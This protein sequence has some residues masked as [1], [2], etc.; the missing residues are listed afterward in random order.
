MLRSVLFQPNEVSPGL[1]PGNVT[2]SKSGGEHQ[3]A[4][5]NLF[6]PVSGG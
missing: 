4:K 5:A 1:L 2:T 6:S 3:V